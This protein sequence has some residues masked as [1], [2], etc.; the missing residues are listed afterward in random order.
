[1][2]RISK[3]ENKGIYIFTVEYGSLSGRNQEA[4]VIYDPVALLAKCQECGENNTSCDHIYFLDGLFRRSPDW[5]LNDFIFDW[6]DTRMTE[7]E[8]YQ[9]KQV[10]KRT[11]SEKRP[12]AKEL[13]RRK[14]LIAEALERTTSSLPGKP[15]DTPSPFSLIELD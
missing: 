6:T 10:F 5:Q 8:V 12:S 13:R 11:V 2:M 4:I 7:Q 1:M 15:K 14:K 9:M 3:I